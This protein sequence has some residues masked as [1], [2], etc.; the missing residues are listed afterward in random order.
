MHVR[1]GFG[2][3]FIM[4]ISKPF[5][6]VHSSIQRSNKINVLLAMGLRIL[7]LFKPSEGRNIVECKVTYAES[8]L[9]SFS[10]LPRKEPG[11][12]MWKVSSNGTPTMG[13]SVAYPMVKMWFFKRNQAPPGVEFWSWEH[14]KILNL[15]NIF[16][17][18]CLSIYIYWKVNVLLLYVFDSSMQ[19]AL[20]YMCLCLIAI[21]ASRKSWV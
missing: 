12:L 4:I 11:V 19:K 14:E 10:F 18:V 13:D 8:D 1:H 5:V 16:L 2:L 3:C 15:W 9:H 17:V 7:I 21:S 20:S 6:L